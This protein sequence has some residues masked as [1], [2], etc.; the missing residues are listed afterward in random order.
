MVTKIVDLSQEIG[1]GSAMWPR[2]VAEVQFRKIAFTGIRS[3]G[4]GETNHPGWYDFG[5]PFP[6]LRAAP[7]GAI[8][9]WVGHLHA[10]THVEAPKYCIPTGITADKIPLDNLYGTGVVI[11]MRKKGKWGK[12]VAADFEEATPKIRAGDFVVVNTGWQ[13]HLTPDKSYEWYHYYPGLMPSAAEWL[14]KKK[15]KAI[16]GTWPAIDH[17]LHFGVGS[18]GKCNPQLNAD[19]K[20]EKGKDIPK[21][22]S[23]LYEGCLVSLLKAGVTVIN[24]AGGDIDK[25]TGQR[26]TLA[27]WPFRMEDTDAAMVRL[28]SI[29]E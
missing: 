20:K 24:G 26:C 25:V 7:G 28:V 17:S 14:I 22:F 16:A 2:L 11:D 10:G 6:Y 27:A 1:H 18:L 23:W 5:Q 8:A 9:S 4:W 15:V 19:Y 3:T 21:E 29:E 13:K 12:I